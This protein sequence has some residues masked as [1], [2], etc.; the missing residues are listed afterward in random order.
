[1]N[2]L[3][4]VWQINP[5]KGSGASTGKNNFYL[6][7]AFNRRLSA[8]FIGDLILPIKF[9]LP[10]MLQVSST[11]VADVVKLKMLQLL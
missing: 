5:Q 2:L 9:L 11:E 7:G 4:L 6:G 3:L 10:L 1:M 8:Y